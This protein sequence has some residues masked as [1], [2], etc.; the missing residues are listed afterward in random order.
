MSV[1][2]TTLFQL[3]QKE[4]IF[5]DFIFITESATNIIAETHFHP[6]DMTLNQ[7]QE[8]Q[9]N[10]LMRQIQNESQSNGKDFISDRSVIDGLSYMSD[11]PNIDDYKTKISDY[12]SDFPYSHIFYLPIEFDFDTKDRSQENTDFQSFVDQ[13]LRSQVLQM[14]LKPTFL[15]GNSVE[16]CAQIIDILTNS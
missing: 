12:L 3:L 13:T 11:F 1:G 2:K 7:R 4:P 16:R 6:I 8:F 10:V 15:S 14:N 5:K 9:S